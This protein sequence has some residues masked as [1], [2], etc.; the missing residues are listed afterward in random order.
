MMWL[1]FEVLNDMGSPNY[2][3]QANHGNIM[4]NHRKQ[5]T[6]RVF[7]ILNSVTRFR[8][9]EHPQNKTETEIC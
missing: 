2:S 9:G 8:T 4:D 7:N 3:S 6:R 5:S 1:F